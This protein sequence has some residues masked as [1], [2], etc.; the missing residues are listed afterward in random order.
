M[1]VSG[2]QRLLA[3]PVEHLNP[4][5][6]IGLRINVRER[7]L[8]WPHANEATAPPT[9]VHGCS[10][11]T[12][13]CRANPPGCWSQG[14]PLLLRCP[15]KRGVPGGHLVTTVLACHRVRVL[16]YAIL[17]LALSPDHPLGEAVDVFVRRDDAERFIDEV[18]R[19]DPEF[20]A[21]LR[22]L[23]RELEASGRN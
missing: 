16:V 9:A 7:M 19:D 20:A 10:P 18:R 1:L 11:A 6:R 8:A 4:G 15:P 13:S 5:R 3:K 12:G 23:E 17:D 21:Y 14:Y 2:T 22:I